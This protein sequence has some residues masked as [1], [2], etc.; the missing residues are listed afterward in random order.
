MGEQ[1]RELRRLFS[2]SL[3]GFVKYFKQ[4][5]NHLYALDG[6][7]TTEK[8]LV[9]P[10]RLADQLFKALLL[11]YHPQVRR[12]YRLTQQAESVFEWPPRAVRN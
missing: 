10:S 11:K 5:T 1:R 4:Y 2:D 12:A 9:S 6:M 7:P 8:K 3:N